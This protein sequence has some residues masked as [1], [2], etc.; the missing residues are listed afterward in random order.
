MD[1]SSEP[2]IQKEILRDKILEVLRGWILHS[3]SACD[4]RL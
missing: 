4:S 3:S 1:V 2:V